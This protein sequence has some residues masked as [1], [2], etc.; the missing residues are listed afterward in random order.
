MTVPPGGWGDR[1][2]F[3]WESLRGRQGRLLVAPPACTIVTSCSCTHCWCHRSSKLQAWLSEGFV[4]S[5]FVLLF[6]LEMA[7]GKLSPQDVTMPPGWSAAFS[8]MNT[9]FPGILA[10]VNV[11]FVL[12][13]LQVLSASRCTLHVIWPLTI[14]Y[15]C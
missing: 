15:C 1:R 6:V 5:V 4:L 2:A 7:I 12:G 14:L 10:F 3:W 11:Y 9:V 8:V 13:R